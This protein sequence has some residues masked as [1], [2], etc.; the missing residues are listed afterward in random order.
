MA[1]GG[2]GRAGRPL[3]GATRGRN[4]LGNRPRASRTGPSARLHVARPP[5]NLGCKPHRGG[6]GGRAFQMA[7]TAP[8]GKISAQLSKAKT[9]QLSGQ[10][11][12]PASLGQR[13]GGRAAGGGE[14]PAHRPPHCQRLAR[15]CVLTGR[16]PGRAG[17]GTAPPEPGDPPHVWEPGPA[18]PLPWTG[19]PR[20]PRPPGTRTAL[21]R[22]RPC[23]LAAGE[24]PAP[25]TENGR[26]APRP[27]AAAS[28]CGRLSFVC[29]EP[30]RRE[31]G[32]SCP[33]PWG[34]LALRPGHCLLPSASGHKL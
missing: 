8:V 27:V 6:L 26:G 7:V 22:L 16:H 2:E 24:L 15:L 33:R 28:G 14:G 17:G 20:P 32:P 19:P 30:G 3:R 13:R 29:K 12:P 18:P 34:A 4:E 21:T 5:E 9:K 11:H 31:G 10:S 23:W 1:L 25:Q